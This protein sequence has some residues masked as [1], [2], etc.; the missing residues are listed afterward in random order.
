MFDIS[1]LSAFDYISE[2]AG[3]GIIIKSLEDHIIVA[4]CI[5]IKASSPIQFEC[6]AQW[7][8]LDSGSW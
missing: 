8:G 3:A 5:V 6:L 7:E 4:G 1:P 2:H